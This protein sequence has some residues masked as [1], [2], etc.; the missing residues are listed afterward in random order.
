MGNNWYVFVAAC[1]Q[2]GTHT[3]NIGPFADKASAEDAISRIKKRM[4]SI[5]DMAPYSLDTT[6]ERR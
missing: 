1:A 3:N 6:G 5:L 4:P 2:S